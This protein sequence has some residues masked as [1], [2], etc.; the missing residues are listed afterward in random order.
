MTSSEIEL[1]ITHLETDERL[2]RNRLDAMMPE[3]RNELLA[4]SE[5]WMKEQLQKQLDSN[6][7][8]VIALGSTEKLGLLKSDSKALYDSLPEVIASE[9]VDSEQWPHNSTPPSPVPVEAFQRMYREILKHLG[10][11][12]EKFGILQATHGDRVWQR[13]PLDGSKLRVG[14]GVTLI[15]L[16]PSI[17]KYLTTEKE[18][19][20][21]S[22]KLE[23]AKKDL[24]A[25]KAKELW[26]SA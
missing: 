7:Q 16:S 22:R 12:L 10:P 4:P 8:T 25:A 23:Q 18:F 14:V 15:P 9:T 1:Q 11:L 21:I 26:E 6:P 2:H 13:H 24:L 20:G 19:R 17:N 5:K 3:I